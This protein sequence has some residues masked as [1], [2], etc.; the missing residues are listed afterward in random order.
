MN[1]I[2][3]MITCILRYQHI[4][5]L[6]KFSHFWTTS[7]FLKRQVNIDT[8]V[9]KSPSLTTPSA[10]TGSAKSAVDIQDK[11]PNFTPN[12]AL[13]ARRYDPWIMHRM[14]DAFFASCGGESHSMHYCAAAAAMS[15]AFFAKQGVRATRCRRCARYAYR[16]RCG[17]IPRPPPL[18]FYPRSVMMNRWVFLAEET[19]SSSVCRDVQTWLFGIE[20]GVQGLFS[21]WQQPICW[22]C[23]CRRR[24]DL[25]SSECRICY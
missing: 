7:E 2:S 5:V 20:W 16:E 21:N 23:V 4:P 19:T 11:I 1:L 24:R 10:T 15:K 25:N 6:S 9:K 8:P 13:Y 17:V 18:H 14:P 12:S 3:S 22:N